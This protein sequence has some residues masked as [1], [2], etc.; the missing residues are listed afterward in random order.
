V[1][2]RTLCPFIPSC[3]VTSSVVLEIIECYSSVLSTRFKFHASSDNEPL[4][5]VGDVPIWTT[6]EYKATPP[7]NLAHRSDG[8]CHVL[9]GG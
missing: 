6:K 3:I 7:A 4:P 5:F 1:G 8:L 2:F 9:V